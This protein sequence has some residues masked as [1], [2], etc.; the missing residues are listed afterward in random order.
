MKEYGF[1]GIFKEI[2]ESQLQG[3]FPLAADLERV[4]CKGVEGLT[5][6]GMVFNPPP[7][8]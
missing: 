2:V 6:S 4:V 8:Q 1:V 3:S 5:P 7:F